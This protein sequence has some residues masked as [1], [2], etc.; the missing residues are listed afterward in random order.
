MAWPA[1][2]RA[3]LGKA[4]LAGVAWGSREPAF[5]EGLYAGHQSHP[6][7]PVPGLGAA[8][9]GGIS[10]CAWVHTSTLISVGLQG[11]MCPLTSCASASRQLLPCL[12]I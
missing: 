12:E 2:G 6:V 4:C 11:C 8:A 10:S 1:H 7:F 3:E 5:L 9:D